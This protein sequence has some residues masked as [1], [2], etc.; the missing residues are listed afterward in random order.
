MRFCAAFE[1]V[2]FALSLD[3]RLEL[4]KY[5]DT[6]DSMHPAFEVLGFY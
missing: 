3:K 2:F 5:T 4:G 6:H 1:D